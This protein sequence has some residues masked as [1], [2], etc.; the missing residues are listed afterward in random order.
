VQ[1]AQLPDNPNFTIDDA[2]DWYRRLGIYDSGSVS[3]DDMKAAIGQR[4]SFPLVPLDKQSPAF[5][6]AQ[7]QAAGFDVYVY[8]NRF[9]DGAGGWITKTPYDI[10]GSTT[11]VAMYG[12]AQYGA[13]QYGQLATS[14]VT[15]AV[16]YI[17]ESKDAVFEAYLTTPQGY[18]ST[19][20]ITGASINTFATVSASRKIEFRQLLLRLKHQEMC[21]FCFVNYV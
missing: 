16:N 5:I 7:L 21:A 15:K 4:M 1:D 3:L 20:Y 6:Q 2:H 13:V 19:F 14:N 11:R 10:L 17:E 8:K 18:R 12:M 9:S